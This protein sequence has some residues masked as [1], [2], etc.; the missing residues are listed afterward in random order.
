MGY[1]CN[2]RCKY[3]FERMGAPGYADKAMTPEV[4]DRGILYVR[5]VLEKLPEDSR[6]AICFFEEE[7]RCCTLIS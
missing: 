7:N 2:F 1:G 4:A 3:C 5:H 6:L